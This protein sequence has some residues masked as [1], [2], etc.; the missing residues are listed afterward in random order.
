MNPVETLRQGCCRLTRTLVDNGFAL[1]LEESGCGS[2]GE[3]ARVVFCRGDRAL[4]LHYRFSLGLVT[5]RIGSLTID[6]DAY[7]RGV[8]GKSRAN[9]FPVFSS[10]PTQQFEALLFDLEHFAHDFLSGSGSEFER[11]VIA[12]SQRQKLSPYERLEQ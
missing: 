10:D 7:M 12:D 9:H 4:E 5:Y 3:F 6:H 8:L 11:C 2:G 1:A